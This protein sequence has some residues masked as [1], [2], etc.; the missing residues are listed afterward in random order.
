MSKFPMRIRGAGTRRVADRS[1]FLLIIVLVTI[2]LITLAAYTFTALMQVEEEASRLGIRQIQSKYLAD[3]GVDYVRMYLANDEATIMEKGGRWDAAQVFMS[4]AVGIDPDDPGQIGRFTVISPGM[5]ND[6][7]PGGFRYG[8]MDESNKINV[9]TLVFA[10]G[11]MEN[12]G[13]Q[14]LMSLPDMTESIADAILDWIDGDEEERDYGVEAGYYRALN[15]AYSAKNGPIDSLDELLLVR[16]VTPQLLFG[17]DTNRNGVIDQGELDVDG[18]AS[19]LNADSMLG[20][21]AYLTLHSKETNLNSEGLERV[22]L[23]NPDLEQLYTDLRSAFNE[24]WTRFI[25]QYRINGPYTLQEDDPEPAPAGV[26]IELDLTA[27]SQFTFTQIL[28]LVDAYTTA[29]D[30]D[31]EGEKLILASP[32]NSLNLPFTI[33]TLMQNAT[34]FA[35]ETIPG[36]INVMQAPR[37][38]LAA[39]PGMTDDILDQLINIREFELDDPTMTDLNRQY[40]TW[41]LLEG[42]VDLPTMRQ[43]LPFVCCGGDVYQAEVTGFYDD[44]VGISRVE[45]IVDDTVPIPRILFWRDKTHLGAGFSNSVLGAAGAAEQ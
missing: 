11:W 19:S 3:S 27:E 9:N 5:D 33:P 41:L 40:E 36:R 16:G 34:T 4:I 44:G 32:L 6:G 25:I 17:Q 24:E 14:L 12:G 20:W 45:V 23:N 21:A 1:G 10:D 15:P 43:M 30:P 2:V 8:L 7:S 38:V 37:R 29:D 31:N 13:R 18:G 26:A 39:I 42:L 35:G 22:N 28:D